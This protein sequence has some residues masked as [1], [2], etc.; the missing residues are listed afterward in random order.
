MCLCERACVR[1]LAR[2]D[3]RD[4]PSAMGCVTSKLAARGSRNKRT[5]L[6]LVENKQNNHII[7]DAGDERLDRFTAV[8]EREKSRESRSTSADSA[9]N[10]LRSGSDRRPIRSSTP[11]LKQ[12]DDSCSRQV[13]FKPLVT[14]GGGLQ[15]ALGI[16]VVSLKV[17]IDKKPTSLD[18]KS[19]AVL[20]YRTPHFR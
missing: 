18:E 6:D 16:K 19:S 17:S 14:G 8:V 4:I 9:P 2:F 5:D 3:V 13:L 12:A 11:E 7:K 1:S 10:R 20:K 15:K